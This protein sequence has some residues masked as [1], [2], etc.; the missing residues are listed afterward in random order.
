MDHKLATLALAGA[1]AAPQ[2]ALADDAGVYNLGEIHVTAANRTP[3]DSGGGAAAPAAN[4]NVKI[5]FQSATPAPIG[6][7]TITAKKIQAFDEATLDKAVE[8]T[9]GVVSNDIA[10]SRNEQNIYVHGFDRWQVPILLDGVRIYLPVDNRLDFGRFLTSNLAEI[11]ISKGY[12][13]VLDGPGGMGGEINLV[14]RKPTKA[15][16]GEIGTEA[17]FSR[18]GW[19]TG[20]R[21]YARIGTKQDLWYLQAAGAFNNSRGWEL[22]EAYVGNAVQGAGLRGHSATKDRDVN[23][24]AGYTPNGSDEYSINFLRQEGAKGAPY[25]TDLPLA[26]N[27]YWNWPYWNVQTLALLTH[28]QIDPTAY[29]NTKFYWNRFDNSLKI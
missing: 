2:A 13:S 29:V 23:L 6:G 27:R 9:P 21:N 26:S 17:D 7:D 1:L 14:T 11:Q 12:A 18:S 10:G 15:V 24:K 22:P 8:L 28:T 5:P 19:Y 20:T 16:E 3:D 25:A 4:A